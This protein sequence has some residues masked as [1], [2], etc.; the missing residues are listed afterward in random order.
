MIA[1]RLL[2]PILWLRDVT[3]VHRTFSLNYARQHWIRTGLIVATVVLGVAMLV[4][5]RALG[6]NLNKAGREAANPLSGTADIV[7]TNGQTG[8]PRSVAET[9]DNAP[10]PEVR[11]VRPMVF[12]RVLIPELDNRSVLV[13]ATRLPSGAAPGA[14]AHGGNDQDLVTVDLTATP[15]DIVRLA[16]Q[17]PAPVLLGPDLARDLEG[18]PGGL[19]RFR[20]RLG[21]HEQAATCVG[22]ARPTPK[23]G[24][25]E[26][27]VIYITDGPAA[28]LI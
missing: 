5:T 10:L 9:I 26:R 2:A 17:G 21:G 23:A 18:T 1:D 25:V 14:S 13:I 8:V 3:A 20:L 7:V 11:D 27:N 22:T 4:A 24:Q 15:A 6:A 16:L 19:S 28:D 12:G